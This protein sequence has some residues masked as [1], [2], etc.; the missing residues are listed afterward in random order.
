[1]FFPFSDTLLARARLPLAMAF[2]CLSGSLVEIPKA[3]AQIT[4]PAPQVAARSWLLLDVTSNQMLASAEPDQKLEP[5]SLTKLMTAYLAF[6]AVKEKRLTLD[7]R[8]TVSELAYKAIGS[9]MFVDPA[10]PATVDQLLHG[11]IIQSGNDAA[12]ILAEAIAGSEA[13]FAKLMNE[14]AQ[15]LGMKNSSFR[16]ATGLPDGQ[17]FSS[18]RD[19][20]TLAQRLIAD[21]PDFYPI[22]SMKEYRYNNISQANRNNLLFVDPT[23]DG[24]KTGRTDA[25][26]YCLVA[27]AKRGE[28]RL[29]SV[30]MG[31]TSETARAIEAQ[32]LLNHGFQNFEVA[33][34]YP[35][36]QPVGTYRVWKGVAT[37]VKGVVPGGITVTIPKGRSDAI[38][39]EVE[40]TLPLFAPLAIGQKIGIVRVKLDD[41]VIA[42]RPLLA[43]KAVEQAGIFGRAW[44]TVQLWV[45]K[46]K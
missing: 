10:T 20:A 1:M 7:Q 2:V 24:V 15:R 32:R 19:M 9:R 25:A 36:S 44:D 17:H 37:D 27:S 42:E 28:R 23:V 22:Y 16:N 29:I 35:A 6:T 26:G 30:V 14:Q 46:E 40:R 43:E 21:F 18:A 41:K 39:A 33:K 45:N 12:I 8:P 3:I 38:K 34:L 4:I 31:A 11:M 5:A 13:N